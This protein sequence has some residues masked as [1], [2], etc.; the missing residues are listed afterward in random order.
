[1]R[2]LPP[3]AQT[4][5]V[6]VLEHRATQTPD[7]LAYRFLPDGTGDHPLDWTYGDLAERAG[8][9][10]AHLHDRGLTQGH[11]VLALDPGLDY[12]AALFGIMRAGCTAVP[13][14]PPFGRRAT[15]RFLSVL[16]DCAPRAVLTDPRFAGQVD[17]FHQQLTRTTEHPQWIFPEPDFYQLP[18][19]RRAQAPSRVVEPA[20]VQ[21]S[22]GS[23][24]D[25]KGIV[26]THENLLS[27]C[28]VLHAH[29]GHE[30]DRVGCS[31]LP[32]YHDMGLMG[33]I[34]LALHGGWPL[35]ML[36]PIH[37]VQDPYRWLKAITDH[38][39][40][41]SVGPN[42]AFDLCAQSITDEELATLDLSRLRQV[43]CGSEP[44]SG[45]TM[46]RFTHRFAPTGFDAAS[47]I[48]CYGLAEA[49]LFVSG[50]PETAATIRTERLDKNALE[51]GHARRVPDPA[52]TDTADTDTA[53]AD[54][55]GAGVTGA[56]T[57]GAGV[58]GADTA[59][60]VEVVS[61]GA[62]AENHEVLI[63]DPHTLTPLTDGEI[64]EIWV[65]GASVAAGYLS[66][67]ELS[68]RTFGARPTGG[69]ERAYL[70]T[71]DLGFLLDGELFVTGRLKDLIVISGRNLHPQDIEHS[72]LRA[73]QD[74]RRI[75]AFAVR[76]QTRDEEE[77]VLVAEFRGTTAEYAA[78][79]KELLEKMTAAVTADHGVRPGRVHIGPPGTVLM[80][81]SGKV[82]RRDTRKAYLDGTLKSFP[83]P[84]P[85]GT[86][87]N[88]PA[89]TPAGAP[90]GVS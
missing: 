81:T 72:V 18:D 4:S 26:L 89:G 39:V 45:N 54:T 61:C 27:N 74:L 9:V 60:V 68:A 49:T 62:V 69:G 17:Q 23:T 41:I 20:L 35:V 52:D 5:L 73:H 79:H 77:V 16:D 37:F 59:D 47:L 56:D 48:P 88:T 13:C 86:P 22:S 19:T 32:P 64:G 83:T 80:T 44:V 50:K 51:H 36:S 70:R 84:A 40:T 6:H 30:E 14:F 63:A 75:A 87:A 57:V 15:A 46:E 1:M 21:Y 34:M 2:P 10:A 90:A 85:A 28:R 42:F 65:H 29:M 3:S 33:T 7:R 38:K 24:G 71:G 78:R 55:T 53:D 43:F 31:W 82:R 8:A 58:T 25:P 66:R 76:S 12:V 67:P 11:I